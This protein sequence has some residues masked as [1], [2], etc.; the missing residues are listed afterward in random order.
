M[1][2]SRDKGF[3]PLIL[4]I[5]GQ[6]AIAHNGS[7]GEQVSRKRLTCDP[8]YGSEILLTLHM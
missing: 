6:N 1:K 4:L 3:S 7:D 5:F 8:N 2:A